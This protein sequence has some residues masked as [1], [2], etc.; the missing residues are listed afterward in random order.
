[1]LSWIDEKDQVLKSITIPDAIEDMS[2]VQHKFEGS[3]ICIDKSIVG[4]LN[5]QD[6][7]VL[8]DIAIGAG[9]I[10]S[11]P[12]PV[13]SDTMSPTA[14]HCCDV[15]LKLYSPDAKSRRWI[16]PLVTRFGKIPRV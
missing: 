16:P 1:M 6:C 8:N 3:L 15:S 7:A 11:I 13:K 2:L 9:G 4:G 10:R 12:G 5:R 14:R